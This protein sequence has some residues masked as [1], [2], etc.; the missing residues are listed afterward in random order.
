[1]SRCP[2]CCCSG[3]Q[4]EL[5]QERII[6][7][8]EAQR[9]DV[10]STGPMPIIN[11]DSE[12]PDDSNNSKDSNPEGKPIS[13]E[14]GD[15]ILAAGL[16][17]YPSMNIRASSTISQRLAEAHQANTEAQNLILEYLKEFISVFSK[18]SFDTLL[19]L[20]EWDHAIELIPG[21]KPSGCKIYPL[22]PMEQKELDA[23][24]KENLEMGRI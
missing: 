19:E 22:S 24:L 4:D 14:E 5:H 18:Q 20:K 6:Q 12:D 21:S 17:P 8:A 7:K 11:H 9:M 13:V 23:F 10:C 3:C 1:M 15:R 16:F 2:P